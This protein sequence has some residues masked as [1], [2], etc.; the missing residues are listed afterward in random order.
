MDDI[1]NQ[2]LALAEAKRA[3]A[4][5]GWTV[6][7]LITDGSGGGRAV[8]V[9]DGG[10]VVTIDS[11]GRATMVSYE[12]AGV[13][14]NRRSIGKAHSLPSFPVAMRDAGRYM[15]SNLGRGR[16]LTG[17]LAS[18]IRLACTKLACIVAVR[19][20]KSH[21]AALTPMN[22]AWVSK[23]EGERPWQRRRFIGSTPVELSPGPERSTAVVSGTI[24]F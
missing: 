11:S 18:S 4:L 1:A 24:V 23:Y 22:E 20:A 21:S 13:G 10:R 7:Q 14:G 12:Q 3:L 19:P 2:A 9:S 8:F 16:L 15:A 5:A 6:E 17:S